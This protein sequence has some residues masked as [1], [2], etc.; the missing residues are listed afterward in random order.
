MKIQ[1]KF[2]PILISLG[3]AILAGYGFFAANGGEDGRGIMFALAGVSF[4]VMLVGGFGI[5]Y[6]ERGGGNI[7][8]LSVITIIANIIV[9]VIFVFVQF[10]PAP[11]IIAEGILILLYVGIV[12]AM[13]N[14]LN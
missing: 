2:I 13:A 9:N 10:H 11:Y 8:V 4:F 6:A 12:Y 3:I 5:K 14:A 1:F 7:S